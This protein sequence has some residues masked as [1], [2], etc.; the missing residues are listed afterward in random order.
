MLLVPKKIIPNLQSL[1]LLVPDLSI[2]F[3]VALCGVVVYNYLKVKD[4]RAT[5][6]HVPDENIPERV[7][8]VVFYWSFSFSIFS[9]LQWRSPVDLDLI[10]IDSWPM[11]GSNDTFWNHAQQKDS[12]QQPK[13]AI[14]NPDHRSLTLF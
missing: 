13:I 14:I 7:T 9:G 11:I 4:V 3:C 1:A 12:I 10:H 8:K 6:G 5:S 2:F